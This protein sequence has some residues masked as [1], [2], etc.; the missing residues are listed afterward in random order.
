MMDLRKAVANSGL[1]L[2]FL[3]SDGGQGMGRET[4]VQRQDE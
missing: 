3:A 2:G 1:V 4:L